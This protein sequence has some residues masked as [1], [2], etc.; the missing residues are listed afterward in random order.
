MVYFMIS[1]ILLHSVYS[2]TI[3]SLW[4]MYLKYMLT[5]YRS[6]ASFPHNWVLLL[7]TL[8]MRL[9]LKYLLVGDMDRGEVG[10]SH[11][12]HIQWSIVL[13]SFCTML[14]DEVTRNLCPSRYSIVVIVTL[15]MLCGEAKGVFLNFQGTRQ[16]YLKPYCLDIIKK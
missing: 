12:E 5:C 10:P 15:D 2:Q 1:N 11:F 9:I 8:C 6:H 16:S 14:L 13:E 3:Q 7:F 4:N